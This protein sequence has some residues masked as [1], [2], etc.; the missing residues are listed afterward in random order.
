MR[1]HDWDS[2]T[3]S[4]VS[5]MRQIYTNERSWAVGR[6]G[7]EH[8]DIQDVRRSATMKA[9]QEL[10]TEQQQF[11]LVEACMAKIGTISDKAAL[12]RFTDGGHCQ[13]PLGDDGIIR[14]GENLVVG[15][16]FATEDDWLAYL[17]IKR[18][19][20]ER[21]EQNWRYTETGIIRLVGDLRTYS[22][23]FGIT[24][25]NTLDACPYLFDEKGEATA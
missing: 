2:D 1:T 6:A 18:K 23:R 20:F 21:Q 7:N 8:T 15:I 5:R 11:E 16:V 24:R 13:L 10:L 25:P 22:Q 12:P 9:A 14:V 19:N 4:F 3:E 17:D